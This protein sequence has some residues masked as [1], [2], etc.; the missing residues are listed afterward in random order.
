MDRQFGKEVSSRER[1]EWHKRLDTE[2]R[3]IGELRFLRP[4]IE[5]TRGLRTFQALGMTTERESSTQ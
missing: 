4:S 5:E 2:D 3:C 1:N